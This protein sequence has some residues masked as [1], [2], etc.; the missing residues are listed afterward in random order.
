MFS[1]PIVQNSPSL[2]LTNDGSCSL[3]HYMKPEDAKTNS[4]N[5]TQQPFEVQKLLEYRRQMQQKSPPPQPN[6]YK[7]RS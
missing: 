2:T 1:I 4:F 3:E 6:I 7:R 5:S